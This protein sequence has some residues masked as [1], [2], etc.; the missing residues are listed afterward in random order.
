MASQSWESEKAKDAAL[1][2][3]MSQI[4][5]DKK[6]KNKIKYCVGINWIC[7]LVSC[8]S[9]PMLRHIAVNMKYSLPTN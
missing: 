1:E 3:S 4:F 6:I 5:V 2:S 8:F 7:H 9:Q